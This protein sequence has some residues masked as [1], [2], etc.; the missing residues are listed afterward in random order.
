[1]SAV[2]REQ[3]I[4]C[5]ICPVGCD[6]TVR[7]KGDQIQSVEGCSCKRGDTYARSEFVH[8]S[9]ILTTTV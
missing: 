3:K 8:P 1:M 5:I 2:E 4:T 7:G 6:I 9:R